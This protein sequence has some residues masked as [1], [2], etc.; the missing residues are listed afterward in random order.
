MVE[1]ETKPLVSPSWFPLLLLSSALLFPLAFPP[2]GWK[3]LILPAVG[4]LLVVVAQARPGAAFVCGFLQGSVGYGFALGWMFRLFSVFALPLFLFMGFFTGLFCLCFNVLTRRSDSVLWKMAVAAVFWTAIEFYRSELFFLRFPWITAG[5]ALGPTHLSPIVGV[6]GASFLILLA[7][8]GAVSRRG[9]SLTAVLCAVVLALGIFRPGPVE[10]K[11]DEGFQIAL[12]QDESSR[13]EEYMRLSEEIGGEAKLIVWPEY[14]LAYDVREQPGDMARLRRLCQEKRALLLVG[15]QT[16]TGRRA[17]AWR[18][19][20]LLTGPAG[21]LG[22]YY[23]NRPVH[24]F[25]DGIAG[26]NPQPIDSP[27]GRIGT[28]ICFDC[29]Y[30]EIVRLLAERGAQFFAVPSYDKESWGLTQHKQHSLLFR[31][32]AAET[33]RWF[34]I[35]ASS[36]FTQIIDPNGHVHGV[37]PPVESGTLTGRIALREEKTFFVRYGWLFP[38][39]NLAAAAVM[40]M[41]Y[42]IS[43]FCSAGNGE[44]EKSTEYELPPELAGIKTDAPSEESASESSCHFLPE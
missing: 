11:V 16:R 27:L 7:V 1:N 44:I 8:G 10:L 34:A 4:F 3:Y 22:E 28:P 36:G 42:G 35:A 23:K 30:T 39:I 26:D 2:L 37:L 38:W 24:F 14:A 29:D 19:T 31:H 41:V 13:L 6:Y 33:G 32:R 25:S 9:L 15:T 40:C 17:T 12:V 5:S 20:A 43:R 21:V 18:N